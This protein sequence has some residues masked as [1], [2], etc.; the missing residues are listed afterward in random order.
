MATTDQDRGNV[1]P[2]SPTLAVE[3]NRHHTNER[4]KCEGSRSSAIGEGRGI[5]NEYW[6]CEGQSSRI[7][8]SR[9]RNVSLILCS[10]AT[11]RS[12]VSASGAMLKSM[13]LAGVPVIND[14]RQRYAGFCF[15]V[16]FDVLRILKRHIGPAAGAEQ[17]L[18]RAET[19]MARALT[20]LH[21]GSFAGARTRRTTRSKVR[22]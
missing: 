22:H 16:G 1:T 15:E 10:S 17:Q 5:D 12:A 9:S 11:C 14:T 3:E 18:Q 19:P 2:Y 20:P 13:N 6:L 7:A 8:T 21:R 4:R